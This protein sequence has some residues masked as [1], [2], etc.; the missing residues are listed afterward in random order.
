MTGGILPSAAS[1]SLADD[2]LVRAVPLC[3]RLQR[4]PG[5]DVPKTQEGRGASTHGCQ[6]YVRQRGG[7]CIFCK[8]SL[9]PST[10]DLVF[11][12]ERT[13]CAAVIAHSRALKSILKVR[14]CP[15]PEQTGREGQRAGEG[16]VEMR[17]SAL[18]L[19][20]AE[21]CAFTLSKRANAAISR[22][23]QQ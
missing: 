3:V 5:E 4:V 11:A 12:A 8:R 1:A 17:P 23:R 16:K 7:P 18:Q 15:H 22:V 6:L 10:K 21:H 19:T 2:F 20:L 14:P 9:H 13:T